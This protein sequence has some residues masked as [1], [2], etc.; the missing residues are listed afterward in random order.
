MRRHGQ[1]RNII[2]SLLAVSTAAVILLFSAGNEHPLFAAD[3]AAKPVD[4]PNP[5]QVQIDQYQE[6]VR[7]GQVEP[8]IQAC[9]QAIAANPKNFVA[10]IGR[11]MGLNA[12]N[13]Y[14]EAAKDFDQALKVEGQSPAAVTTRGQAYMHRSYALNQQ[15]KFL[16]AIDSAYFSLLEKADNAQAHHYRAM[17]YIGW[18]KLDKSIASCNRALDADPKFAEALS[19]RGYVYGLKGDYNKNFEDQEKALAIDP[20]LAVAL[21]RRAA[22]NMA[23]G[24]ADL[25][26]KD[27]EEAIR[28]NPNSADAYCDRAIMNGMVRNY[29]QALADVEQAIKADPNSARARV[30]YAQAMQSMKKPDEA[31]KSLTEAIRINPNLVEALNLRGTLYLESKQ[32][33][34]ALEDFNKAIATDPKSLASY[35]GRAKAYRQLKKM[36]EATADLAKIRELQPPPT[37]KNA[38]KSE[39]D[40]APPSFQV[41]SKGV[42]PARRAKAL[43]AAKQIDTLVEANYK[44]H[45]IEPNPLT[46]DS[47]FVRRIYLDITGT[48]PTYSQTKKFLLSKDA[49]KRANLI[50]E[51]LKSD[52]YA[53]HNFNYWADV[54]RYTDRLSED[55]RGEPYRQWIKQSLAENKPWDKFVSELVTAEGLIWQNP[56]TGYAQRDANMP[57]DSMNNTVR[58]FLGTRIGCAQCHNHPFDRWTQ[59]EFYEMAAF[60]FG[61]A[62]STNGG[63]KRF[64]QTNPTD[65]LHEEFAEIEQEEEERRANYYKFDAII[66]VNMRIVNNQSNKQIQLPKDYA[67]DDAKP[68]TVVPPKTIFGKPAVIKPGETRQQAFSRWLTDKENPRF[69][70]TIANR[71]WKQSFG[72]GQIEPVDDMTDHTEAENPPLMNFLEEQMKDLNF[73]MKEYLRIV[74]NTQTYQR[75]ACFEEVPVGAVYHFP[76][77]L[78]RRMS[79]EQ[80]WDSFLTLTLADPSEYREMSAEVRSQV[81]GADLA[82]ISAESLLAAE[83]EQY[84][85]DY[86][87]SKWQDK[88]KY[89]GVLLARASELPS[90]IPANHFLRTFGQSDRQQIASSSTTGS[91][92]QVLFMFN[93]PV[94]HMLLEKNSTIYNNVMSKKTIPDRVSAIFMTV[95]NREPDA[96]DLA[97]SEQEIKVND[98][99]GYGN[100][101]WSLVN[102]R[103]FLFI[104]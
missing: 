42:D 64:W 13:K 43:D 11:G 98:L 21:Q 39:E 33:D 77:P 57:L 2:R 54:L 24:K 32:S 12:Q 22:A 88:H 37:T 73:D 95:L 16:E 44:K 51:L 10:Y 67:Y 91:V 96:E 14:D 84:S 83:K 104:Q 69:A 34:K 5:A 55:V 66:R 25:A 31:L 41:T 82:K 26:A 60:T 18:N 75:Q 65:R 56:A 76:G 99:P 20:K 85:V 35:Q 38:K 15:G 63:D 50:D 40:E 94:S 61:T 53:S 7:S 58:I 86:K 48:I 62:A 47:Q 36:D 3:A 92:P 9:T 6:Q 89:K 19:T 103:E 46:N 52:G 72:V 74:Y 1:H 78:L 90:P 27:I 97:L 4:P 28:I 70:R 100:V 68:S 102:T 59:K 71:L 45:K 29:T 30:Q 101:I 49:D 93:G 87:N 8:L 79:A 23:K 17:A 81:V 80:V